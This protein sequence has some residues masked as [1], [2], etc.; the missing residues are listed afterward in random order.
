MFE[1]D[2]PLVRIGGPDVPAMP[3][4]TPLEHFYMPDV[5]RIYAQMR[6]LAKF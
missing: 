3:F 5:E 1:L 4:S 2:G 6:D